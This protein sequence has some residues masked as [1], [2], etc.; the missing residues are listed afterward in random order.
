V[1]LQM[2]WGHRLLEQIAGQNGISSGSYY[3]V[4]GAWLALT[5]I[6][7]VRLHGRDDSIGVFAIR[8]DMKSETKRSFSF[9]YVANLVGAV[10]GAIVPAVIHRSVRFSRNAAGR[11]CFEF[12]GWAFAFLL[13][14]VSER[15]GRTEIAA[16][17]NRH[18]AQQDRKKA[19]SPCCFLPAWPPW[20]WKWFGFASLRQASGQWFNSFALILA[21]YLF[22]TFVGSRIYR[23]WSRKYAVEGAMIW[24]LLALL[25]I[26]PLVATDS[27]LPFYASR[28]SCIRRRHAF[29]CR[30]GFLTPMLVG[31]VVTGDPGRAGRAYAVNVLGC[32]LG[33]LL[34]GFLVLPLVGERIAMLLFIL[35]FMAMAVFPVGVRKLSMPDRVFASS[36]VAAALLVFLLTKDLSRFFRPASSC[37]IALQ[38]VIATDYGSLGEKQLLVNGIPMTGIEPNHQNDGAPHSGFARAGATKYSGYLLRHGH[39]FPVGFNLGNSRNRGGPDSQ[40]AKTFSVLSQRCRAGRGPSRGSNHLGRWPAFFG[41]HCS[42]V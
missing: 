24:V 12:C 42:D 16:P 9:L 35:P 20:A 26:L 39:H 11:N 22:A 32:I 28:I 41:T 25:G 15:A 14:L 29:L 37:G 1:P 23:F 4:A 31:P 33:P 3:L 19:F 21:S 10:A 8:R 27:T 38:T 17:R 34:A 2:L 18:L 30:I 40:R 36:V 13:S 6:S 5:M 7:L